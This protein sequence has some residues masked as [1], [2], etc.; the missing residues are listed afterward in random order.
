MKKS[1]LVLTLLSK[2]LGL[3]L[4]LVMLAPNFFSYS[5]KFSKFNL[6]DLYHFPSIGRQAIY[7][8]KKPIKEFSLE[9]VLKFNW[10]KKAN[11]KIKSVILNYTIPEETKPLFNQ[12][13]N[14]TKQVIPSH[15]N[16]SHI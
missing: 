4:K 7:L 10:G 12:D 15:N 2:I 1:V 5:L 6:Y 11:E 14:K 9:S 8:P 16:G 3:T 13:I